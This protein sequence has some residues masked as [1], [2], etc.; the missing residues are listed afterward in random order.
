MYIML[1]QLYNQWFLAAGLCREGME[2][3]DSEDN[4][5]NLVQLER[6]EFLVS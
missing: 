6:M 4:P 3:M 1:M 2:K 5:D